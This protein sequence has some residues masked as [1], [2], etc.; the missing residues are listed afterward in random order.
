MQYASGVWTL[1]GDLMQVRNGLTRSR[2][3]VT[4]HASAGSRELRK[5]D[6]INDIFN[7]KPREDKERRS[8]R[9]HLSNAS[10]QLSE[11]F[12]QNLQAFINRNPEVGKQLHRI[13]LPG[14]EGEVKASPQ[15]LRRKVGVYLQWLKIREKVSN[16]PIGDEE[17]E[18]PYQAIHRSNKD[19]ELRQLFE[20]GDVRRA[21]ISEHRR[22]NSPNYYY[23][24]YPET[25]AFN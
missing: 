5:N 24:V 13:T 21:E 19:N 3:S 20:Q 2:S 9:L 18:S 1:E 25:Y 6:H 11:E 22:K 10:R 17:S 14:D 15:L 8:A 4:D 23:M 16:E 12:R 7:H